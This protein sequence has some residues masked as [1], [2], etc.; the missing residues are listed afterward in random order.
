MKIRSYEEKKHEQWMV[1]TDR[2]L[3]QRIKKPLLIMT[4][5]EGKVH[6]ELVCASFHLSDSSVTLSSCARTKCP[7]PLEDLAIVFF[8][9]L[10]DAHHNT[11]SSKIDMRYAVNFAPEIKEIISETKCLE[12]LG[13]SVPQLAQ[14]VALQEHKFIR[15]CS[16]T[17]LNAIIY[18]SAVYP[19]PS[20]TSVWF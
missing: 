7:P 6:V 18:Q 2:S 8:S 20:S 15:Y 4:T 19:K 11:N 16:C 14:N 10:K 12:P 3:P 5:S 1:E 17:S 13:Y 9:N